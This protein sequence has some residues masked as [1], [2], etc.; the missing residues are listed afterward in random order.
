MVEFTLLEVDV[1]VDSVTAR[2]YAP[3]ARS[4]GADGRPEEGTAVEVET[5][6]S[7]G[8][9][10]KAGLAAALVGLVFLLVAA[11]LLRRYFTESEGDEAEDVGTS[12]VTIEEPSETD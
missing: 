1:D 12:A 11:L 8:G 7:G 4:I 9:R 2:A 3:F 5:E 10:A 6:S